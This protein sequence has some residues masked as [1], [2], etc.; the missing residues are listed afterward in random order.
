M[1]KNFKRTILI[2]LDGVLN[3]YKGNFDNNFIPPL[4][5]GA[6][7]FLEYLSQDYEI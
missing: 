5:D 1:D 7:D 2:D 6:K 4:K 3:E